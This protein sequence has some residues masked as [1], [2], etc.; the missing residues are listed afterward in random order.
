MI[1]IP[2]NKFEKHE[3]IGRIQLWIVSMKESQHIY[4]QIAQ[5]NIFL[6]H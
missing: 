1:F 6:L 2:R 3:E 4:I 5:V